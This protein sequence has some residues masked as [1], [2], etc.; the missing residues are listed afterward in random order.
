MNL[1]DNQLRSILTPGFPLHRFRLAVS[2]L[3]NSFEA[4][5]SIAIECIGT[6]CNYNFSMTC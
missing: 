2:D 5:E 1:N 6:H 3:K 4:I